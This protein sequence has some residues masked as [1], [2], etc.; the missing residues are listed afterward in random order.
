MARPEAISAAA[1]EIGVDSLSV[2]ATGSRE[3]SAFAPASSG[4][5]RRTAP[6]SFPKRSMT[7]AFST[8]FSKSMRSA[9]DVVSGETLLMSVRMMVEMGFQAFHPSPAFI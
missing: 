4:Q 6:S 2:K 5:A 1:R 8:P 3:E 7:S 9:E